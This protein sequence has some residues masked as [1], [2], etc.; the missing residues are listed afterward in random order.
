MNRHSTALIAVLVLSAASTSRAQPIVGRHGMTTAQYQ[1][2]A[3]QLAGQ[4]YRLSSISGYAVGL[5]DRYA[6]I[7]QLR[8]GPPLETRHRMTAD[9]Y[10]QTADQLA[11]Q[12]YQLL[13]ICG[14]AIGGQDRY[15]AIW[16][17]Q[18]GL[19]TV[20]R[21]AM[22]AD[23][24]QRA[25]DQ[26]AGQG[27]RIV[28]ISGYSVG[29]Q[30]LYAAIWQQRAGPP[31]ESRHRLT[32]DQYQQVTSQLAAQGYRLV[33]V[34]GYAL[35]GQDLYAAIWEQRAGPP[36]EA[37]HRMT[38]DQYQQTTN[39]MANQGYRLLHVAGYGL[40]GQD[41]YVAIWER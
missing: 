14:Y 4:G 17:L 5:Q 24:Y 3:E 26:L 27:Y 20:S 9:Q 16:E 29:T 22:T 8:A 25:N 28:R 10:Q 23:Q 33:D 30:D 39:Q 11:Q 40:G 35:G 15:A 6:A 32:S 18:A 13:Y 41:R 2:T 12:G 34:S 38:A 19:P 21:H 1:Q 36:F 37:R 7:W 31:L